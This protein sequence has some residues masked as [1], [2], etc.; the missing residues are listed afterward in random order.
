VQVALIMLLAVLILDSGDV[1]DAGAAP[2]PV[3]AH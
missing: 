3:T 1:P 2:D